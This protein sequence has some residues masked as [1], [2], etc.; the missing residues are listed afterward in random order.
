MHGN[1][2]QQSCICCSIKVHDSQSRNECVHN[3]A[4]LGYSLVDY[5]DNLALTMCERM[6]ASSIL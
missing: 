3:L 4:I 5:G 1:H 6:K 2:S